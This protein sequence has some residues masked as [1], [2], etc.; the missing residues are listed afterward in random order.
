M[1]KYNNIKS[2]PIESIPKEEIAQ[3]ISEWAEGDESLERLLWVRY[4]KEIKTNG[5][6]AGTGPYI[7][8][9]DQDNLE[10]LIPILESAQNKVG[11]QILIMID[12][13]NPFSGPEWYKPSIGIRLDTEYKKEADA[14]FDDLTNSLE[15]KSINKSH[16][17]LRLLEYFKDKESALLLRF[18][19]RQ[20]DKYTFFIESR[21]IPKERYEY[22]NQ[23]FRTVGFLEV[24]D[25]SDEIQD[26]HSWVIESDILDNLI[27]KLNIATDYIINN[28][29]LEVSQ[30]EDEVISFIQQA[31]N[32]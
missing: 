25:Y 26:H 13:G 20:E 15:N 28:Y 14:F 18:L 1:S 5:C 7:D 32:G 2:I 12:G 16:P 4:K 9:K 11:V 6:H 21:G 17:M 24:V 8:F 19:H 23:L 30:K 22:Y 29:S 3:A 31:M 10:K 27:S